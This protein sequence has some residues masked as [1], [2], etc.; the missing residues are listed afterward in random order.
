MLLSLI[1]KKLTK[2][3]L[4]ISF[5]LIGGGLVTINQPEAS[6]QYIPPERPKP[7]RTQGGGS[8]GCMNTEPISL[9]LLVPKDHTAQTVSSHPT[10]SWYLSTVP[11]IPLELALVEEGVAQPILVEKLTVKNAGLMQYKLPKDKS[12]LQIGKEYRWTVSLVCNAERPSQSI[13]ARAWIERSPIPAN[14]YKTLDNLSNKSSYDK[15]LVYIKAG[16]WYDA[17]ASISESK[18][19][20][21]ELTLA[22]S[23]F[24][25]LLLQVG[26]KEASE[27]KML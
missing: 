13:Y 9:Q 21:S 26:L 7:Q 14:L 15:A 4:Q 17:I 12:G 27:L 18:L 3:I 8:R 22:S 2:R 16:I 10:L 24:Q 1:K 5:A 6:A 25:G 11:S 23:L 19:S 20:G